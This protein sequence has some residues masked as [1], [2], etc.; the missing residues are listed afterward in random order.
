[1]SEHWD[2]DLDAGDTG[3]LRASGHAGALSRTLENR[4]VRSLRQRELV[5][6]SARMRWLAVGRVG[7]LAAAI[8]TTFFLGVHVG[9]Q[10]T[11]E[12]APFMAPL[13]EEESLP[14]DFMAMNRVPGGAVPE[15]LATA[16]HE[17]LAGEYPLLTAAETGYEQDDRGFLGK[18]VMY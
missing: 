7:V 6:S 10:R 5:V 18:P 15:D 3:E 2:S 1:M 14:G 17:D 9:Q 13:P 11:E 4:V 8:V 16:F 12:L